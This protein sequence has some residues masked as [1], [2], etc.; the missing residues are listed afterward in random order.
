MC[1]TT[2]SGVCGVRY[3]RIFSSLCV[4]TEQHFLTPPPFSVYPGFALS[5]NDLFKFGLHFFFLPCTAVTVT[6]RLTALWGLPLWPRHFQ[7]NRIIT[8]AAMHIPPGWKWQ[9]GGLSVSVEKWDAR[10]N[11][12]RE[13]E[14]DRER[15]LN[16]YGDGGRHYKRFIFG[17]KTA[18][19]EMQVNVY[20]QCEKVM[21]TISDT[22]TF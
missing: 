5:V 13:W 7:S 10:R 9:Y 11:A 20:G 3:S 21:R 19:A 18:D 4:K 17:S 12:V 22:D 16:A 2:H 1:L 8:D 14:K 6:A 15:Q